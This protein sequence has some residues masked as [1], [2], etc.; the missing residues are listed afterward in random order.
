MFSRK[1]TYKKIPLLLFLLAGVLLIMSL[2][3]NS[4]INDTEKV[5]RKTEKRIVKRIE[6]LERHIDEVI[7]I[8]AG[9][10]TLLQIPEDMVIYKY[11]N[12]SLSIW[13]NQFPIINDDI[14]TRMMIQRLTNFRV[15]LISPLTQAKEEFSYI[16]LG[17]KWYIIKE[18]KGNDNETIIA[19]LEIKNT[20]IE[21]HIT[22]ENGVNSRF[23]LPGRFSIRPINHSGGSEINIDG[24]PMF[25]VICD[26][27][28]A[29]LFIDNSLLRWAALILFSLAL[30]M[31][32]SI[33]RTIRTYIIV[34][35]TL[36]VLCFVAY[37][38]GK[39]MSDTISI[40]SP[41]TYADGTIFTSLGSL[42]II[43]AYISILCICTY[44]IN[45]KI[46]DKIHHD[47][48]RRKRELIIHGCI[49]ITAGVLIALYTHITLKSLIFN[50]NVYLELHR[51]QGNILFT[52]I[53]YLSFTALL[54]CILLQLQMLRPAARELFRIRYDMYA[55]KTIA[56]FAFILAAYFSVTAEAY[57][58]QKEQRRV[59]VWANMLA[60]ERDLALEIQLRS[61]ENAIA[62]D[63]LISALANLDNGG[64][65]ILSRIKESYLP[66]ISQEYSLSVSI[67]KDTDRVSAM[68]FNDVLNKGTAIS[69]GSHFM[70]M[71]EE[72]GRSKY[73]G[74]FIYYSSGN[75]VSRLLLE[76]EQNSNREDRGYYSILGMFSNTSRVNAP[77]DY[78]YAKYIDDKLTMFTGNYPY[79]TIFYKDIDKDEL[80]ESGSLVL[81]FKNHVHFVSPVS[82]NEIIIISRA[83][84]NVLVYFTSFSY[85]FLILVGILLLFSRSRKQKVFKSNYYR[86]RINTILLSSSFLILVSMAAVSIL[87]VY[88]RNEVNMRNLM[89]SKISTVQALVESRARNFRSYQDLATQEFGVIMENICNT[90][91]SDITF[92]TPE[93]KVFRST[94]PEVFEK[95]I[96]G[97]RIDQD[98][99]H[100]ICKQ[101]QRFYI[102]REKIA[103]YSYWALYAPILNDNQELLA[104]ICVPYTTQ[105]YDFRREAFF[106][107]SLIISLFILLLIASLIFST[108]EVDSMF[109]PLIEMGK[110]MNRADI[111]HL[112]QIEYDREDEI[113][114]LVDAYN[115]MVVDLSDSTQKLALAER[116]K[117]WSQM[118]RQV[119]HEIKNPLTPIKLQIQRL[120][121]LKQRGNEA[122]E[123]KFDKVAAVVLE[124]IDILTETANEFSTFA[125]LYSE[126]PVLMDLDK[127]L[128]DQL[129]IFDNK[130]N[131]RISYMGMP[132]AYIMAPK[133]QLIRVFVNLITNAVQAVENQQKE[134]IEEGREPVQGRV[135]ICLRNSTKE[136][137]YDVVFDDN[138]PGV[139]DENLHKLFTPNFTTKSGGTGLGLAICRNIIEKCEGEIRYQRSF[140]L[141]GA[142]FIVTLPVYTPEQQ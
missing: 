26:T 4:L 37:L 12:D 119:A 89:S 86:T 21:D 122:W 125:K 75:G 101:N 59:S 13:V 68:K 133:P 29:L 33:K 109:E 79:P 34:V 138:G 104:I 135:L 84:R 17:P 42:L 7:N 32:L 45:G 74:V 132:E 88:K 49:I 116:D 56:V 69:D 134:A 15:R 140:A 97:S 44:M 31:V 73:A 46:I 124:H 115:R 102:N 99:Y 53:T 106:H 64:G 55:P 127:I 48:R 103:D 112:E 25:K 83:Q 136:G 8:P 105:N 10:H 94:T 57:G 60:V 27:G 19:G 120:I 11:M 110:K 111:H 51:I 39:Q 121:R 141:G 16:N 137:Y 80:A 96:I 100:N 77:A 24:I 52:I 36:S 14:S 20:L 93:G 129:L 78:S 61:V 38:W 30:L 92:Y 67:I 131:V 142:S 76:I 126:E 40:F 90:T 139:P 85:L 71:G 2:T 62:S 28:S 91:K 113:S 22:T 6:V 23:N 43:N 65:I 130:E 114:S 9:E 82:S 41:N 58:F 5:A 72:S 1:L 117:A 63:Q 108:R 95:L 123:E 66:R 128:Q 87:F 107:A 3:G 18:V 35:F 98:A 118:A 47:K 54:S 50:S 81:R 70:F